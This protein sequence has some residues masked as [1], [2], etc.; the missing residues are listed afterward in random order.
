MGFAP[1]DREAEMKRIHGK[2]NEITSLRA[3]L[4][5]AEE[6]ARVAHNARRRERKRAQAA[7]VDSA[8]LREI[9]KKACDD[10]CLFDAGHKRSGW[11]WRYELIARA[12]NILIKADNREKS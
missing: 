11:K 8:A 9:I 10:L 12:Q 3:K 5:E 2:D 1:T 7:E 6:N 4:A